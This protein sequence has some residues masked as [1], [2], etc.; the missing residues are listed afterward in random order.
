MKN[1]TK[2]LV[3]LLLAAVLAL[4][5]AGCTIDL[6]GGSDGEENNRTWAQAGGSITLPEGM[7]ATARFATQQ[8]D[9]AMYVVFNGI[10]KRNTG[11]FSAPN[12]ELTFTA[13]ATAE[14]ENL[15]QF[16]IAVW[17]KVEGGTQYVDGSTIYFKT[18]GTCYTATVSGLDPAASYRLTL[19]YDKSSY[20]MYGQVRVD[21]VAEMG[22]VPEDT[23]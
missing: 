3:T 4:A 6:S 20:Y 13:C 11:Y 10:Q 7:D 17:K 23:E 18:D 9:G 22:A 19:S 16:K 12:G 2:R 5:L 15:Q 14:A 21:G 1:K 8:Q